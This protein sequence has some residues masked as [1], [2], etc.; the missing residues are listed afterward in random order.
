LFLPEVLTYLETDSIEFLDKEVFTDVTAGERY[1]AD[2]LVKA[3]FQGQETCFLIHVE[4]QSYK[5]PNIDKAN[6]GKYRHFLSKHFPLV[7]SQIKYF[8]LWSSS[9]NQ[10]IQYF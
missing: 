4:N 1:E 10:K 3:K 8:H 9:T 2:L 5:Q 6:R 7:Y